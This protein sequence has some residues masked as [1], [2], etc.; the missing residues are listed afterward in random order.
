M[1]N[2]P[3]RIVRSSRLLTVLALSAAGLLVA[4]GPGAAAYAASPSPAAP[5]VS[6][7]AAAPTQGG[8]AAAPKVTFGV[9][10]A[11]SV[12]VND[13]GTIRTILGVDGRPAF[14][15]SMTPGATLTDNLAVVNIGFQPIQLTVYATDA[16]NGSDG[17]FGLLP[18]TTKPTDAGSWVKLTLP[19][20][21]TSLEVPARTTEILPLRVV[22]PANAAPGDHAAGLVASLAS[23][24]KDAN[25]DVVTLDQRVGARMF[26]RVSG[27]LRP[28]LTV[29]SLAASYHGTLNPFGK[30]EATVTYT[31]RNTGNVRL[32]GS[33]R[34]T[35]S[36]LFGTTGNP[37]A[38]ADISLL[39]PGGSEKVTVTV[40]GVLP[41]IWMTAH[42]TVSPLAVKGDVDP[43]LAP[44]AA[45]THFWAIPW[46][47][48]ALLVALALLGWW[49]LRRRRKGPDQ[50]AV[51]ETPESDLAG[52]GQR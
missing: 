43:H 33:Q 15:Y 47:L 10:P 16:V 37:S 11:G 51:V 48:I 20:G 26:I 45:S 23:N 40:P 28:G 6:G 17:S 42:V 13:H 24:V 41:T 49:L 7:Q 46:A 29:D 36:G 44:V 21:T 14:T 5:Q 34:V 30:G 25:G 50:P 18:A 1:N 35:I 4:A 52:A 38:I 8:K 27:A 22:V 39:L 32:A 12:K 31:V 2:A 19:N 3:R 9:G